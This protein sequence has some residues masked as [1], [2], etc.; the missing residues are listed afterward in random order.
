MFST[1]GGVGMLDSITDS[2]IATAFI[3]YPQAIVNLTDIGW[4]NALFGA[5]FYDVSNAC[6]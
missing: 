5:I 2:G 3:V 4:F 1:M 6:D